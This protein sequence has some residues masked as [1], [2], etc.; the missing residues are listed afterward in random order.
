MQ[1]RFVAVIDADN[2]AQII[3]GFRG[4]ILSISGVDIKAFRS[5]NSAYSYLIRVGYNPT[6]FEDK[7]ENAQACYFKPRKSEI[8]VFAD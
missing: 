6:E 5:Y 1:P 8:P 3:C 4:D 2:K 7:C